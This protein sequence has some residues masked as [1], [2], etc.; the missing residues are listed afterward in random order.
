LVADMALTPRL[1]LRQ[2]QSLV[3]TPQLQQA[4]KLLQLSNLELASYVEQ[5]LEENPLLERDRP[6]SESVPLDDIAGAAPASQDVLTG[7]DRVIAEESGFSSDAALD[8]DYDNQFDGDSAAATAD[9]GGA[10]L[11][12]GPTSA[13]S[14]QAGE[15]GERTAN[16]ESTV[17][18][19]RSLR[20]FLAEQLS[21]DI[22]DPVDRMIGFQL[23]EMLDDAGYLVGELRE[24]A[25]VLGCDVDRVEAVLFRVQQFEPTG[26]FA[27]T[28]AECLS[29]Q[30]RER[31]RLNRPMQTLLEN[32]DVL[33]K[34]DLLA[35][36]KACDVTPVMLGPLISEL[37]ALN[38]KPALAFD[39]GSALQ[40]IIPDVLMRR[41]PA[42][43]WTVE[44]NSETLPRVLV[45]N[46]YFIRL[47]KSSNKKEE[48]QYINE[49]YQTANWLVKSLHQRA[50]TIIKVSAEIVRQQEGF[51]ARGVQDLR[52]LILRDI[53]SAVDLHEST[54]SR[55]TS[56]KYILT[57]R[58]TYELK[59]FFSQGI[60]SKAGGESHSAE[61]VRHRIRALVDAEAAD[62]VLSDDHIVDLL[63][64]EGIDIARR[65][66]AKYREALNIPSSVHRRRQKCGTL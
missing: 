26:I 58:G 21:L 38:P 1:D 10:E 61:W 35:L 25:E 24:V 34:G 45:N 27:R 17:A 2:S 12:S 31:G 54:V 11:N 48:K 66:V 42:G 33:A 60:G 41:H 57:P 44:L 20:D 63:R 29:L 28:L 13:S 7:V 55:V 39:D 52:P 18:S 6:D 23:I 5:Q 3:M 4:I 40:P 53:A 49:C 65:T 62:Q 46:H 32:L 37:R 56:N 19:S 9:R 59:Y 22:A 51:F 47:N 14:R 16:L 15:A 30:L 8:V 64:R 43:G 36:A 50:N